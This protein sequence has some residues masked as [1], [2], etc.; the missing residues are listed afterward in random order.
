[1]GARLTSLFLIKNPYIK[2]A[3]D[4][5]N[6]AGSRDL[7]KEIKEVKKSRAIIQAYINSDRCSF[8]HPELAYWDKVDENH[9]RKIFEYYYN[10]NPHFLYILYNY[11]FM[12]RRFNLEF[13]ANYA[14]MDT[15]NKYFEVYQKGYNALNKILTR[16]GLGLDSYPINQIYSEHLGLSKDSSHDELKQ[17]E[18]AYHY[19]Y[20][21][22]NFQIGK[23]LDLKKNNLDYNEAEYKVKLLQS[24][25]ANISQFNGKG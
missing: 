25:L 15:N 22:Q 9:M 5:F 17:K 24:I 21:L 6:F 18:A 14:G 13:A 16:L 12:V 23:Y 1:M 7:G 19:I 10:N 3:C 20:K 8:T 11:A 2:T 4:L